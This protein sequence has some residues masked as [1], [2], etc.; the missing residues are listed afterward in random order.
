MSVKTL[1]LTELLN[2]G[3]ADIELLGNIDEDILIETLEEIKQEDCSLLEFNIIVEYCFTKVVNDI[4]NHLIE[5]FNTNKY[6]LLEGFSSFHNYLD[7]HAY[8]DIEKAGIDK[9]EQEVIEIIE[10]LFK[11]KTGFNLSVQ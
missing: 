5:K 3:N 7:T 2:C 9:S 1:I 6:E 4:N 11:E 10:Q 8:L